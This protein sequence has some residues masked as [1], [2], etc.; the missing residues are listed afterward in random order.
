MLT[1]S[2]WLAEVGMESTLQGAAMRLVLRNQ[3]RSGH[4]RDHEAG[5]ERRCSRTRKAGRPL[6]FGS[7]STAMRR[8]D[9]LPISADGE[10][11][12]VGREGHR[13]GVKVAAGEHVALLDEQQRIVG[14]GIGLDAQRRGAVADQIEAG[15]HHLRLAAE[16]VR[17]LH[18]RAVQMRGADRAARDQ[19]AV[20]ARP[21]RSGPVG[22]APGGCDRRTARRCL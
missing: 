16:G 5:I 12:R 3:R 14:D 15:A 22:R 2:S 21:P 20:F 18:S 19:L 17:I 10:R 4:L 11:Q 8:S 7:T 6:I 13:L 9:R 1:W